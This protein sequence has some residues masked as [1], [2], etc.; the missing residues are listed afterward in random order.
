MKLALALLLVACGDNKKASKPHDASVDVFQRP[1]LAPCANPVFGSTVTT[2]EVGGVVPA[3]LLLTS[4]PRDPRW[5]VLEQRGAIRVFRDGQLLP[6]PFLDLSVD[7]HG[8]VIAGEENGLLGLAFH[9][10]YEANGLFYIFYTADGIGDANFPQRDVLARCHVGSDPDHADP[11]SCVE[12]LSIGDRASNHN[13]GMIEFGSDGLLYISTGD[14]GGGGDPW[15]TA[16]DPKQLLG[17]ILRID[18]D[19]KDPWRGYGI[20]AGNPFGTEVFM[21]GLRNPWRWSFDRANGDM[22]IADVG[23]NA[24]EELDVLHPAQQPGANLGWSMWEGSLCFHPPCD[25]GKLVFPQDERGH[26]A[27][28]QAII[29]GQVYRGTCYPDL[30]GWYFY[31]DCGKGGLVKARL[32][33]D[34]TLEIVDL[35]GTFPRYPASLHAD[36]R[37]ELYITTTEGFIYHIEAGP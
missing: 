4:P 6:D 2:R 15:Q 25:R 21:L 32:R 30:V 13:A 19:H 1:E 8:P 22:W 27:G 5:F 29:G 35:P 31:T 12:I 14:G 33:S 28:W 9:P 34:D 26:D 20:P 18:I 16:Q 11:K 3:G 36:S 23:Q 17:K 7:A 37:G 24:I 10:H